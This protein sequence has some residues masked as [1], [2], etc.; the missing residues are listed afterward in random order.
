M[1]FEAVRLNRKKYRVFMTGFPARAR[2]LE[3]VQ[4][5]HEAIRLL[6]ESIGK[7]V[8]YRW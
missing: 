2:Q 4:N 6:R 7:L 3:R 5:I 8:H 1:R